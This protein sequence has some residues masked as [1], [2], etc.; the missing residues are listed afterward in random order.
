MKD[1]FCLIGK[2]IMLQGYRGDDVK[3]V[4]KVVAVRDTHD[5]LISI[6][7]TQR[8]PLS[9]GRW[10]V[11]IEDAELGVTKSY[12]IGKSDKVKVLGP[13]GRT[14]RK[15]AVYANVANVGE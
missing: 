1:A 14:V 8:T 4:G 3:R 5:K 2:T 13:V 12:Y 11:T 9:R 7:T 15:L 10:L 6:K